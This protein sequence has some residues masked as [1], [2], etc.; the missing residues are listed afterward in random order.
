MPA[1][2]RAVGGGRLDDFRFKPT[3]GVSGRPSNV[4]VSERISAGYASKRPAIAESAS[5]I[6]VVGGTGYIG[7]RL[8]RASIS[9]GH[10]TFVLLRPETL[11]SPILL[12]ES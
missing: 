5:R 3:K 12:G 7:R 1:T 11:V 6:L 2:L 4:G 8:V 9:V 10:P